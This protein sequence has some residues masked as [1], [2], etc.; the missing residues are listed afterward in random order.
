MYHRH[1]HPHIHVQSHYQ[2]VS[3]R[4]TGID[5]LFLN[6]VLPFQHEQLSRQEADGSLGPRYLNISVYPIL[7]LSH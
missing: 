4:Y 6:V 5:L 7:N 3:V 2:E 1:H